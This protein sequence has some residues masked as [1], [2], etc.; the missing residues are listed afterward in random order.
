MMHPG[1]RKFALPIGCVSGLALLLCESPRGVAFSPIPSSGQTEVIVY[2]DDWG[3]PHIY[4]ETEEGGFYGLGYAQAEDNLEG[5]LKLVLFARGEQA[6]ALGAEYV[7]GDFEQRRWLHR[8]EAEKGLK[9]INP[10]LQKNY[11]SYITGIKQYMKDHPDAVP[12]W[13]PALDPVDVVAVSRA[14]LWTYMIRQGE[15]DCLRAGIK[16]AGGLRNMPQEC[17][18]G[19]SN[20]WVVSPQRSADKAMIVLSDPH[21]EVDGGLFYEFRMEAGPI[22]SAGYCF[23]ALLILTHTRYVS[24]GMTTGDPDVSDCYEVEV[25]PE[26]PRRYLYDG[27]WRTMETREVRVA[28]KDADPVSRTGEYTRHNGSLCPVIARNDG[29]AYVICTSYMHEAGLFDEEIY[30]LNLARNMAEVK[31]AVKI[32]GMFPQN[33]MFG[34]REGNSYYVRLGRTPR[35]PSGYDWNRPVEGNTSKT[36]WLGIHPVEDLVQ[37]ENPPQGYMQNCNI[38]PDRMMEDCP[39]TAD[40]YPSYIFNDEPNRTNTR[41]LRAV[42]VLS[43]DFHFTVEDAMEL[44]QDEKWKGTE[45]WQTAL[46]KALN[47]NEDFVKKASPLYRRFADNILHFDGHARAE[48]VA[49]LNYLYWRSTIWSMPGLSDKEREALMDPLWEK[50]E[51]TPEQGKLLVKAVDL[52]VEHMLKEHG[53]IDLRYGD[54]HRIGRGGKSWP[55]GGGGLMPVNSLAC[56]YT[57]KCIFTLRAMTFSDPDEHGYRFPWLGS[58]CLRLVIFTDPIQSFTLH[59]FGQSSHPDSPHYTDQARLASERRLK[60]TYFYKEDLLKHVVSQKT[61][62]I[63]LPGN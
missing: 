24:W 9:R 20:E 33:L 63:V 60:P 41:G 55:L 45:A 17:E 22:K 7:D 11:R 32:L 44:A 4:S 37:I 53:T 2:R 31:D 50:A 46:H 6:A 51:L 1:I 57:M 34:D 59:L 12:V 26:N 30:R 35:R 19:A 28:V 43:R 36:A 8:E 49:A 14:V 38:A 61:I 56:A 27:E 18:Q 10:Q 62:D 47:E 40:R 15:G 58:R 52:A 23:G 16:L 3:V 29:K 54:I 13:A 21:G 5:L 39:L 25:D 48:S 42:E